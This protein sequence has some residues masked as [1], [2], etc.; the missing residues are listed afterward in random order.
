MSIFAKQHPPGQKLPLAT[1]VVALALGALAIA[2]LI[3]MT[4]WLV[5]ANANSLEWGYAYDDSDRLA[6]TIDPAGRKTKFRYETDMSAKA[7]DFS[8]RKTSRSASG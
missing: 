6:M 8:L 1:R 2:A 5:R 3:A 7:D 4:L